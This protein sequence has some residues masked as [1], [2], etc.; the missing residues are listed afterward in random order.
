MDARSST[1]NR[2][3]LGILLSQLVV[4]GEEIEKMDAWQRWLSWLTKLYS[5]QKSI[6][7]LVTGNW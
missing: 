2:V 3:V 1:S 4:T 5:A 7:N 6:W